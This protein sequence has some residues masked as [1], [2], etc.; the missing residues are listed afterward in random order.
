MV[1]GRWK[2]EDGRWKMED[3]RWKME[4]GRWKM[5]DGRGRGQ[6]ST[7]TV[8]TYHTTLSDITRFKIPQTVHGYTSCSRR[9]CFKL[10]SGSLQYL[11]RWKR[12]AAGDRY[13]KQKESLK[14]V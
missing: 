12:L 7:S 3:G 4:D 2:M 6:G 14:S 1:D 8:S 5:E 9:S 11:K 13:V 10:L